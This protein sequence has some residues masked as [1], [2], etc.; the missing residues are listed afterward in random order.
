[1]AEQKQWGVQLG[2]DYPR[3]ILD[4]FKSIKANEKRYQAAME[5]GSR[6]FIN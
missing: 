3:P 6:S 1:V 4:F 2:I 5:R